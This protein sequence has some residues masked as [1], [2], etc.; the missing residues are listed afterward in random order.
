MTDFDLII[1]GGGAAGLTIASGA[2]QLGVKVLLVEKEKQMGGDCLHHG[3]VPSK[4]LIKCANVRHQ[5]KNADSYGLPA[6]ELEPV[7]FSR[8]SAHIK[9]VIDTIQPHDSPERFEALGATVR[10]GVASFVDQNTINLKPSDGSTEERISAGTIVIAAGSTPS[11]P[12]FKGLDTVDYLTNETV[13]SLNELPKSLTVIGGGPIAVELAQALQRLGSNVTLLQ[14]SAHILSKED[15][16]MAA[17]VEKS[18][19]RDGVN[20]IT[21]TSVEEVT[22]DGDRISVH[23]AT[24]DGPAKK[25]TSDRL[26]VALGRTPSVKALNLTAA[27]IEFSRKGIPV[28]EKMRT[29]VPHIYAVGDITGE[30]QFTHA[31]GYEGGIVIANAI[32]KMPRKANYT[33]LPWVTYCDPELA[34]IGYNE[35]RAKKAGISYTVHTEPFS[36]NDR[37]IAENQPEGMLKLLMDDRKKVIGVQ[38]A[39]LHAGELINEWVAVLGG[40]VKL[41]TLAGA[42]HPYPTLSEINKKVAGTILSKKIFSPRMKRVL[43]LLF[44]YRGS[45]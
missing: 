40:K 4:T 39:G 22:Q 27:G 37:A 43:K 16:D 21:N 29:N 19:Q 10:F 23:Y 42:I 13:F 38:I 30:Y 6:P 32:F 17:V 36:T 3:C 35:K 33:L 2:A 20:I 1:I 8:I 11:H 44:K 28:D 14:R 41:S 7:D 5:M 12:P 34:S 25:V 45:N 24:K 15:A 9:S 18:L 26:L 31:A